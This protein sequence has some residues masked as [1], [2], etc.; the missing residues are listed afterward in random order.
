LRRAF[1]ILL[2]GCCQVGA[3][4]LLSQKQI[5]LDADGRDEV[6]GLRPYEK[7]RVRYGQ[8]MVMGPGGAPL[9]EAPRADPYIFLGEFDLGELEVVGDFDEDG[10]IELIGTYQKSDVS[11]TRFRMFRWDG[12]KFA[13]VKSG[14]LTA[15][16]QK[17]GTFVWSDDRAATQWVDRLT[18][19]RNRR[20]K[21][22]LFTPDG[23]KPTDHSLRMERSGEFVIAD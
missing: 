22:S 23:G 6:I 9:W 3:W 21:A 15:A 8:L 16:P 14:Y 13:H 18:G 10:R 7:D 2:L 11:P 20:L 17:P 19:F 4:Q 5:D 12:K 1:L